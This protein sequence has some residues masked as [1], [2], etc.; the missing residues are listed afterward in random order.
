MAVRMSLGML[1]LNLYSLPWNALVRMKLSPIYY[2]ITLATSVQVDWEAC[3]WTEN[4]DTHADTP[5]HT[6]TQKY[7]PRNSVLSGTLST[8]C[9]DL[10]GWEVVKEVKFGRLHAC[11]VSSLQAKRMWCP[12]VLCVHL[13][14]GSCS[15]RYVLTRC[16]EKD[17]GAGG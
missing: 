2:M 16:G 14:A 11:Q 7:S 15:V 13:R 3:L 12:G 9:E 6:Q 8:L 5:T 1:S 17:I 10:C 4:T